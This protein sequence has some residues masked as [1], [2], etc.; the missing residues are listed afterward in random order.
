MDTQ[1]P[2]SKDTH[3]HSDCNTKL[4]RLQFLGTFSQK[5][6][7]IGLCLVYASQE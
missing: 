2:A 6:W 4:Q 5:G 7:L 3:A 1:A